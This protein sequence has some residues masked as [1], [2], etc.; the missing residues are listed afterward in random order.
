MVQPHSGQQGPREV[1]LRRQRIAFD[2]VTRQLCRPL[3][4]AAPLLEAGGSAGDPASPRLG[5]I[6]VATFSKA[7]GEGVRSAI[8]QLKKDGADRCVGHVWDETK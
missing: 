3:G 7:T 2:A 5:Y 8:Q 1:P 6:R 4:P